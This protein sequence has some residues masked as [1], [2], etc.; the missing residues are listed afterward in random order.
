M[1]LP[2]GLAVPT[3]S[4][5][6]DRIEAMD[7]RTASVPRHRK[8]PHWDKGPLWHDGSARGVTQEERWLW[9]WR[10]SARWWAAADAPYA[11][12]LRH[13]GLWWSKQ[14]GVWFAL[15]EGQLW[16]WRRFAR[17]DAEGLIRLTDG[18]EIVYSAD[19]T[20]VAVIT[21]GKGAVLYDARTGAELGEWLETELPRRRP[22]APDDLR[23][24]RG[25]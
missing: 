21:P 4:Y 8:G 15:H 25:I 11:S 1:W 7:P 13:R 17:W 2:D 5:E 16:S 18:V 24:P 3:R 9:L 20:K 19:F 22:K 14:K 6:L 10:D 12:M 23:L